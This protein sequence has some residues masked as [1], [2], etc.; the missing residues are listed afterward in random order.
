MTMVPL[1]LFAV[2]TTPTVGNLGELPIVNPEGILKDAATPVETPEVILP[3]MIMSV[4]DRLQLAS[5]V[6]VPNPTAVAV[7]ETGAV[8]MEQEPRLSS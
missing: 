1:G 3:W 5:R 4:S 2:P 6:G 8:F 7:Y